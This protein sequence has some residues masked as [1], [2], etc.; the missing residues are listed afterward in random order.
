MS[1]GVKGSCNGG[2]YLLEMKV[3]ICLNRCLKC[4]DYCNSSYLSD[5]N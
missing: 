2:G 1:C 3:N 4:L 5:V